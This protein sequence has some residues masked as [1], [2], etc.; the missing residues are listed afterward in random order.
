MLQNCDL[1]H[2]LVGN[3]LVVGEWDGVAGESTLEE[4][5]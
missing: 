3:S 2:V 4:K 5:S 1:G